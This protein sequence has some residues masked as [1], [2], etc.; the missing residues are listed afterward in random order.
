MGDEERSS[1]TVVIDVVGLNWWLLLES[2]AVNAGFKEILKM[3]CA[4]LAIQ[5]LIKV[6]TTS[7]HES[8]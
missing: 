7:L 2:E 5:C 3:T 6:Y 1:K 4:A 8:I